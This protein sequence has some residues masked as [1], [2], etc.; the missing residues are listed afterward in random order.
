MNELYKT[1]AELLSELA[2]L[3]Q[4]V[5][6]LKALEAEC[7]E[8]KKQLGVAKPS[9]EPLPVQQILP[10]DETILRT[11]ID[12]TPDWIFIKDREHRYRLVN[13]S[14]ANS[15][16]LTP[17]DFIGKNDL[18]LGFPEDIVK[19]NPARGIRGFWADDRE[20]MDSGQTRF[21]AEEPAVVDGQPVFLSTVKVPLQDTHGQVWGVL[22]FV[23]D[24]TERK[25][26]EKA[27]QRQQE[28][29]TKII[30]N[31]PVAIFTKDAQNGYRFSIWNAKMEELFGVKREA[32]LGKNDYELFETE[33]EADYYRQTDVA[34]MEEGQ[35]VD[36][37][38]EVVTTNRGLMLA[39]T[40][41]VPIY[42]SDGK[43][44]I[45]LGILDDITERKQAEE[46]LLKFKLGI[47]RSNDA[48]FLTN[49]E[50]VITYVNPAFEKIYGFSREEA[51]GQTPQILKSGLIPQERYQH[52][53][54]TLL[55]KES[56]TGEIV[57]KAKDGRLVN[58]AGNNTPILDE[59]ENIIGFLAVHRDITAQKQAQEALQQNEAL[60]RTVIDATPDWI[61]IKDQTHRYR[62]VN[63]GY[64]DALHLR[65]EE[66]IGKNDLE[67]G[68][69]EE[70][71]KGNPE[72]G[73]RG[74]WADDRL[75]M[76]SGQTQIYPDDPAT[77]DGVT[78][79]F[80]TIKTPLRDADGEIGGVLA[81]ARDITERKR[82][83]EALRQSE[84]R[85]RVLLNAIPD[86][87][88]RYRADGTYLDIKPSR[89]F[90][91]FRSPSELIGKNLFEVA[92]PEVAQK[93]MHYIQ[94][95]LQT[96]QPQSYEH[97]FTREGE[98]K[99]EEI[100]MVPS[101]VAD[102][103]FVVVRDITERR[104]AEETLRQNEALL[105]TIIDSTPDWILVK[106]REHRFR[107]VNQSFADSVHLT[108]ADLLGKTDLDLGIPEEVVKGNPEKGIRGFWAD[109]LEV[110]NSGQ[111]KIIAEEPTVVD[112]KAAFLS[113]AKSPLRDANGEVW[114]LLVF[115]HDI[116]ERKQAEEVLARRAAELQTVAQVGTAT[117]TILETDKL[118]QEV[119]DLTKHSFKLYHAH[120]Y[121][122]NEAGDT[123]VL[124]AGAG[125]VGRQMVAQGWSIPLERERSLVAQ[126]A[127]TRQ[128][129]VANDVRQAPGFLPNPLLPDTHAE[130]AVPLMR[131][132]QL[133]GVLD[134]QA[135]AV[136][137]FSNEDVQIQTILAGQVAAA[138][139]NARSFA[140]QQ[141]TQLLLSERVQEL[142]CLN[143]ISREIVESPPVPELLQWVTER[144]PPAM[145]YPDL[146]QAAVE[147]EGQIY[148]RQQAIELPCQMTHALRIGGEVLGRIYISYMQKQEFLDEESAL[149]GGIASRLSGYIESR[150]LLE[151]VQDALAAQEHLTVELDSQ[152]RT[153]QAVLDNMPAGVFV[154]EAPSGKPLL[155]NEQ[156]KQL[157][158]RG[159]ALDVNKK[160]TAEMY[161]TYRYGTD[162]LYPPDQTPLARGLLGES[163]TI[164][165]MEVRRPNGRRT[166]LQVVGA[167]IRNAQGS[168]S[169]S[170]AI[171]QDITERKQ[172][173]EELSKRSAELE[174]S[175]NFLDSVIENL[176]VMLF[177]KEAKELR[178]V[179]W[180]KTGLELLG[181]K[182][183]DMIGKN[184]YD[185]FP[186]EEADFFVAK[187]REALAKGE[188][189]EIPEE[190]LETTDKGTRWLYTR[191]TPVYG[192][193]GQPKYLL[194][195]SVDITERKRA[196]ETLKESEERFR[197]I[198]ET[199]PIPILISSISDGLILYGNEQLGRTFGLAVADLIGQQTPD[200]Y[201]DP[202]DRA[203]LLAT[204]KREGR[205][206][207]YELHVKKADGTPFWVL[208]SMQ[209]LVFAGQP[210]MLAAFYDV[211]ERKQTEEMMRQ[212][213]ALLRT[214]IDSTPDWIFI[215][216]QN[217]RY[218][219]VNQSYANS[220]HLPPEEF[221]GKNDL[222]IGFPEEI[223][224]G[225]AE[226][227]I[228]GFWAD[229]REVMNSGETKFIA[230]EPAMLDG[231][232]AFLSTIKVPLR[233]AQN[234]VSGVLGFVQNITER[235]Q[236]EL[237]RERL[238]VQVREALAAADRFRQFVEAS[239]QG[240]GWAD[241]EGNVS[242]IN[243]TLC[244][245][246]GEAKPED[247]YG[248]P[249]TM[250]YPADAQQRLLAEIFPIVVR[251]G[252]WSGELP[253]AS[254]D[255]RLIP[256]L[257]TL[258]LVR[259]KNGQPLYLANLLTDITERKQ[260]EL[261][262]ER[263]LAE[264]EA[265]YRQYVQREWEHFLSEQHQGAMR[266]E[267]Q[268]VDNLAL[269]IEPARLDAKLAGL[270]NEVIDEGK[271]KVV[272]GVKA[273]GHSTEPAIVAPIA[274]RGQVIGTLSLQDLIP[275]RQ[276]TAEEVALVETVSEQ[277]AQTLENL[278]LFE[279]TQKQATR[280][281]LTR[282][283]TEKMRAAPDIDTIIQTGLAELAK[284]L[285]VSRTYVKLTGRLE[286]D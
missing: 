162:T 100:W 55:A 252:S 234:Q 254:K 71:V 115:V 281:Q 120:I 172:A 44:E 248:R 132:E 199:S 108:P 184:D 202:A 286:S 284:A 174:E 142:N 212:N 110:M 48:F 129:V 49:P 167:P 214:V 181:R 87:I 285:N 135:D 36:I 39:H 45:L 138:L 99:F 272:A 105:R 222:E 79:T 251:E 35:V 159:I 175:R 18:E 260:A 29:L 76:D 57:N 94:L 258:F 96:G 67:L 257:N 218:R 171:F 245:L 266:I 91:A 273:N 137:Y 106:D 140:E 236:A 166:L 59:Q 253:I 13:Q 6:R 242:Y 134:V 82:A 10:Q 20:V 235:K 262:Q 125:E 43:P 122:L 264:V 193:D 226:K 68:F 3:H 75:V 141:Q 246:F 112:G 24:I 148:G 233:D 42:D 72:K 111:I 53:W 207:D 190:P 2:E 109:D 136:D 34:V 23:H 275:D 187:D 268:A 41:K 278:R 133:L 98:T 117:A 74:F 237:E 215:K 176:P 151:Q 37:P 28:F 239:G 270:Q 113:T 62:L 118:L 104:R 25:Q 216:D 203:P 27:L 180:N 163:I 56:V 14:Y 21:I 209:P 61:F 155:A 126:A 123:L 238:L 63:K 65:P 144:I 88:I 179:R 130:M 50:G 211:T 198:A 4:E 22:G 189:V 282:Q 147:Y 279:D 223:V 200:F 54:A 60:L 131:G 263:L 85:N 19:G 149:I 86:L 90:Q 64:A 250:Y 186:K 8:L 261:E 220:M 221:V 192:A 217:H 153:L 169:A 5:A 97:S 178:H 201:Y 47:E 95:A 152:R 80:H 127:R 240:I 229:D 16:H 247:V 177:I 158:G 73:I 225:N 185:F 145:R 58:I 103:V 255:G 143:E 168:V 170:V 243:S 121:L 128:G 231:Q 150:R 219:L 156:V 31:L 232:P 17:A 182:S 69:P 33:E 78:H 81:F 146:C 274:L 119:V 210:A 241:L 267:H 30:E 102:E 213:E 165:D 276:W 280:E 228:K 83:E 173:E 154:A 52:F 12:S 46:D 269:N 7:L 195:I 84:T 204:L 265:A 194:G 224:K 283:I 77:I 40:V 161:A 256:T 230:E 92:P 271:T 1:R 157:L 206:H 11:I 139:Q 244:R 70:L 66:F 15:L 227:G 124:A 188:L 32:M 89:D 183:E 93:R 38:L 164:D 208:V 197:V 114:G 249:V 9:I 116:T 205:L 26:A 160:E 51:I 191:K 277:L 259:D 196:E 107:L 101:E